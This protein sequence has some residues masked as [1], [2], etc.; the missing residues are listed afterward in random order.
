LG[1]IHWLLFFNHS[2]DGHIHSIN[3][4]CV[5][6]V[7]DK[8]P[9]TTVTEIMTGFVGHPKT[10]SNK[11]TEQGRPRIKFDCFKGDTD[12]QKN[13]VPTIRHC[14]GYDD[15]AIKFADIKT[16]ELV[17]LTG[18]II[19]EI[20]RDYMNKPIFIYGEIPVTRDVLMIQT[21]VRMN[22]VKQQKSLFDSWPSGADYTGVD[23]TPDTR[24]MN[25]RG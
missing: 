23:V 14:V 7:T 22:Y 21:A 17:K 13:K 10:I 19:T 11:P 4:G 16:G 5:G 24:L 20:K 12:I 2:G 18:Y 15:I 6:M 8:K 3:I 9:L 1:N 25:I